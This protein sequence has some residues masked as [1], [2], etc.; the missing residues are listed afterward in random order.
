MEDKKLEA[1]TSVKE[2]KDFHP[3][4]IYL[5]GQLV[6]SVIIS[7]IIGFIIGIK[8][9]V[10]GQ[11][12]DAFQESTDTI[13][14]IVFIITSLALFIVFAI[15]YFKKIKVDIKRI[16][17]ENIKTIILFSIIAVVAN[18]IIST[19]FKLLKISMNNQ[20][21]IESMMN[22][23]TIPITILTTFLIPF[24]EELVFRYA[25]KNII[26]KDIIFIIVSSLLFGFAH[27]IGISTIV[28][29]VLGI[30]FS[31]IYLKTDKNVIASTAGHIINNLS[32]VILMLIQ[33]VELSVMIF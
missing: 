9:K 25:L 12:F 8:L 19:T 18:L 7:I 6:F 20:D 30:C 32:G 28:Y 4:W 24:V 3:I 22:V 31:L 26:K 16:S 10:S 33:I 13:N 14:S 27:G 1:D 17:K 21:T 23:Y 2:K 11:S 29:I 5:V 15:M